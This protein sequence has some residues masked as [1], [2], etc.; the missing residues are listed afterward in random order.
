MRRI[1]AYVGSFIPAWHTVDSLPKIEI[2]DWKWIEKDLKKQIPDNIKKQ[3]ETVIKE[4]FDQKI[5]ETKDL[6][7]YPGYVYAFLWIFKNKNKYELVAKYHGFADQTNVSGFKYAKI[8]Y[9]FKI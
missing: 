6:N 1:H 9:T 3:L 2:R 4:F 7:K 5:Q 8:L